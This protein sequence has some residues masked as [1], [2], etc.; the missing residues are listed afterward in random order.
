MASGKIRKPGT[1]VVTPYYISNSGSS[2]T[3]STV[4]GTIVVIATCVIDG[5]NY[6]SGVWIGWDN[7]NTSSTSQ[8]WLVPLYESANN[9][10]TITLTPG[11]LSITTATSYTQIKVIQFL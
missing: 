10:I 8:S 6:G 3:H 5:A 11:T 4:P 9:K 2:I 7:K 1:M